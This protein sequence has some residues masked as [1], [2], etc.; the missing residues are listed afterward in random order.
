MRRS[1]LFFIRDYW[2]QIIPIFGWWYYMRKQKRQC[3][4]YR[5]SWE[6]APLSLIF[7]VIFYHLMIL[8]AIKWHQVVY[9]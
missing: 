7:F 5:W 4:E 3:T 8:F 6:E 9:N 1:I 2:Y